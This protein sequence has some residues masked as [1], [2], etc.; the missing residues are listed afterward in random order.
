VTIALCR[1][2]A[3]VCRGN[4]HRGANLYIPGVELH[5]RW[6]P[7][8]STNPMV[9]CDSRVC[10]GQLF[11]RCVFIHSDLHWQLLS[12]LRNGSQ[13]CSRSIAESYETIK[14]DLTFAATSGV[15]DGVRAS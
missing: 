2:K 9:R 6:P 5:F 15:T 4:S 8:S 3:V 14:L 11:W 13:Y 1:H 10:I 7:C 12:V